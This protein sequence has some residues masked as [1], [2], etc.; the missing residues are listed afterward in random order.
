MSIMPPSLATFV[1]TTSRPTPRPE[2]WLADS[3]VE[4][5]GRKSRSSSWRSSVAAPSATRPLRT[6]VA[7]TRAR[8]MPPPSSSISMTMWLPR[9]SA[10]S[11]ITPWAGL[12]ARSRTPGLLDAVVEGVAHQVQQRVGEVLDHQLV[13]L[14]LL[15]VHP[16]VDLLAELLREL[17][18]DPVEPREDL[19]DRHHPGVDDPLLQLAQVALEIARRLLE[20]PPG[21]G[22]PGLGDQVAAD[23]EDRGLVDDQLADDVHQAVEL[24]DVHAHRVG[25]RAHREHPFGG[26]FG[27]GRRTRA[28]RRAGRR[29]VRMRAGGAGRAAPA[30]RVH[31]GREAGD[32]RLHRVPAGGAAADQV[33]VDRVGRGRIRARQR[34][35]D[36]PDRLELLGD[37]PQVLVERLEGEAGFHAIE[38]A[39]GADVLEQPVLLVLREGAEDAAVQVDVVERDLLAAAGLLLQQLLDPPRDG[40]DVGALLGTRCDR[41]HR[42][43]SRAAP[44]RHTA[45]PAFPGGA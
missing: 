2:T 45:R 12:P 7:R 32:R 16:Q 24:A 34:G 9:C 5:L 39:P 33:E 18:H 44:R 13:Q 36:L 20:V 28:A 6:A 8:S 35:D 43:S 29:R 42:R 41:P 10:R 37:R 4:K 22:G 3:F 17:A 11:S 23:L 14:G 30:D 38:P 25:E 19:A 15:A 1:L 21:A 31:R 26:R 27:G 40:A